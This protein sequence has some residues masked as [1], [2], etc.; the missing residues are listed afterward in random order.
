MAR[1]EQS[2]PND[3]VANVVL[4]FLMAMDVHF[5]ITHPKKIP[6][7]PFVLGAHHFLI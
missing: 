2:H 1:N 4:W 5:Q 7:F 6:F 3:Y